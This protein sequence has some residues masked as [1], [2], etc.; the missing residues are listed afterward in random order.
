MFST[1]PK[2]QVHTSQAVAA[3]AR[4]RAHHGPCST[5]CS[6]P[7]TGGARRKWLLHKKPHL[8]ANAFGWHTRFDRWSTHYTHS[9]SALSVVNPPVCLS[10]PG[11]IW[12]GDAVTR[13]RRGRRH[14]TAAQRRGVAEAWAASAAAASS[15]LSTVWSAA[16]PARLPPGR[17]APCHFRLVL[18]TSVSRSAMTS[19]H[20]LTPAG[21]A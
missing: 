9:L 21:L 17:I 10:T 15:R 18:E 19:W 20:V 3:V 16:A 7:S 12:R 13:W 2:R 8:L 4:A 14:G 5:L 1:L 6:C 11:D